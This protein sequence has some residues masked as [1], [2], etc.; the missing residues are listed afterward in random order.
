MIRNILDWTGSNLG[1]FEQR[2]LTYFVGRSIAVQLTSY[3]TGLDLAKQ[4]NLEIV[5]I[6]KQL[7]SNQSNRRSAVQ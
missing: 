5:L 2:T 6:Q 1:T 4:V 3:L 7:N